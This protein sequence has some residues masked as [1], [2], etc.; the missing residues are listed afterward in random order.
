MNRKSINRIVAV[1]VAVLVVVGFTDAEEP[2]GSEPRDKPITSIRAEDIPEKAQIIGRLGKPLGDLI[3]IR[4]KWIKPGRQAK[5]RSLTLHV[6]RVNGKALEAA[7]ELHS[8][9]VRTISLLR[10]ERGRKPRPG[11]PWDWHFDLKGTEL[12]PT[13][14]DGEVWEMAGVETGE[15]DTDSEDAWREIEISSALEQSPPHE[16]GFVTRF[17]Y[18]AVRSVK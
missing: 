3:T 2:V 1:W 12:P 14:S 11:E 8:L 18:I 17:K 5:D 6:D 7:I 16:E 15:F 10:H 9:Q 13:R 4:G